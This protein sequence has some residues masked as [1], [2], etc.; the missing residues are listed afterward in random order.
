MKGNK[1]FSIVKVNPKEFNFFQRM[2][3]KLKESIFGVFYVL[4]KEESNSFVWIFILSIIELLQMISFSFHPAVY[5]FINFTTII[6]TFSLGNK[7][8]FRSRILQRFNQAAN[9]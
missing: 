7:L 2:E 5:Y 9:S 4:L 3:L 6:A 1:N 8:K